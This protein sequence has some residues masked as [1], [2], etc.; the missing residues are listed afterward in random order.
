M[1][2]SKTTSDAF[3]EALD[4]I[5]E[6]KMQNAG[7]DSTI[8]G[9]IDSIVSEGQGLYNVK[10]QG[11]VLT[12]VRSAS[13]S[14]SYQVGQQVIVTLPN[15]QINSPNKYISNSL[16]MKTNAYRN[17]EGLGTVAYTQLGKTAV[18]VRAKEDMEEAEKQQYDSDLIENNIFKLC[19][20]D[21][22]QEYVIYKNKEIIEEGKSYINYISVDQN[23]IKNNLAKGNGLIVGCALQTMLDFGQTG[24]EYGI[25]IDVD[26]YEQYT[27]V[28]AT[29]TYV[30][31]SR[32]L[33]GNPFAVS[34]PTPVKIFI[35]DIKSDTY[36]KISE[37][38]LYCRNFLIQEENS[39]RNKDIFISNIMIAGGQSVGEK[40]KTADAVLLID[41]SDNI[42]MEG[43]QLSD[44]QPLIKLKAQLLIQGKKVTQGVK[45]LWFKEDGRVIGR[46]STTSP[47]E[48]NPLCFS[49][50]GGAGWNCVNKRSATNSKN[51]TKYTSPVFYFT[52]NSEDH[53][54][55]SKK[56]DEDKEIYNYETFIGS[57]VKNFEWY[58]ACIEAEEQKVKCVAVYDDNAYVEAQYRVFNSNIKNKVKII[59]SDRL[60]G[61]NQTVYYLNNGSPTLTCKVYD[62]DNKEIKPEQCTFTWYIKNNS[63]K[64]VKVEQV[65]ETEYLNAKKYFLESGGWEYKALHSDKQT[66]KRIRESTATDSSFPEDYNTYSKA[67]EKYE[68]YYGKNVSICFKNK[69]SNFLISSISGSVTLFCSVNHGGG[70]AGTASITLENRIQ[71][72]ER[73]SLEIVNATQVFKYDNKGNS[74]TSPQFDNSKNKIEIQPL[75]FNFV[76]QDGQVIP[77]ERI[78]QQG[79]AV[80]WLLPNNNTLLFTDLT[81]DEDDSKKIVTGDQDQIVN[82]A[83]LPLPASSYNVFSED[84]IFTFKIAD[85]FNDQYVDND[86]VLL[87]EY[88]DNIFTDF[89]NFTF[90]KQGDSG[91]NGTDYF[92]TIR[93]VNDSERLYVNNF[94]GIFDDNDNFK[95]ITGSETAET[96]KNTVNKLQSILYNNSVKIN[97][98][99]SFKLLDT[100]N[101]FITVSSSE[102][103]VSNKYSGSNN[104]EHGTFI[105]TF[106]QH[107][108]IVRSIFTIDSG[109]STTK[110]KSY[111]EKPICFN[112]IRNSSGNIANWRVKIK[113]KTGFQYVTYEDDGTR[114][115]YRTT[116]FEIQV[117][118][119]NSEGYYDI[120]TEYQNIHCT[121]RVRGG[122]TIKNPNTTIEIGEDESNNPI[123]EDA[124]EGISVD[125]EP[126]SYFDGQDL[127]SAVFCSITLDGAAN[128]V[129]LLCAPIYMCINRYGHQALNEWDG[130]SIDLGKNNAT[131]LAPQVGAGKKEGTTFTGIVMGVEHTNATSSAP[132]TDRTG[133]FGY[134]QGQRTIF[135]NAESGSAEFGVNN[136]GKITIDPNTKITYRRSDEATTTTYSRPA[137]L[138]YSQGLRLY[139]EDANGERIVSPSSVAQPARPGYI[140]DYIR[141][142]TIR[143]H[144]YG[145]GMIIDLTSPA[146]AFGSGNFYVEPNGQVTAAAGHIAGWKIEKTR[147][148]SQT[149]G[150]TMYLRSK[151]T[152]AGATYNMIYAHDQGTFSVSSQG[153]VFANAGRVAGWNIA[154]TGFFHQQG[155]GSST[156]RYVGIN[157]PSTPT[158]DSVAFYAGGDDNTLT[159]KPFY[160]TFGGELHSKAG[161]IANWN[162]SS[163]S[164]DNGNVG[165]GSKT[166]S[167]KNAKI[168]AGSGDKF[169]VTDDG[170][171]VA[172]AGSIAGWSLST[173]TLSSQ[174]SA[175]YQTTI[176]NDGT[177]QGGKTGGYKWEIH[178][179]GTATFNQI[180][181]TGGT[182]GGWTLHKHQENNPNDPYDYLQDSLGNV[183]LRSDG[184]LTGPSWSIN[185]QGQATFTKVIGLSGSIGS[186]NQLSGSG[187]GVGGGGTG[188]GSYV[189]PDQVKSGSAATSDTLRGYMNIV[190]E[191]IIGDRLLVKDSFNYQGINAGW[192]SVNC[193]SS[194]HGS[195]NASGV[196]THLYY[197]YYPLKVLINYSAKPTEQT[198]S[199]NWTTT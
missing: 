182:V 69:Y 91:T 23:I 115:D 101:P 68:K 77:Y 153:K 155:S 146:I 50:F 31:G 190:A 28:A 29:R 9:I 151:P 5:I 124:F 147:F 122:L 38:R 169:Y 148:S 103:W 53:V 104:I 26:T 172:T 152:S 157:K 85:I 131:I 184:T 60:K 49:R 138:L 198:G 92:S 113:P 168:W 48:M 81:P 80:K 13:P 64:T 160:V 186:G 55:L 173:D 183:T 39:Q 65:D 102:G 178:R 84:Q 165:L 79:G 177:I 171:V 123:L 144:D 4:T 116:S 114:P 24:G 174:S 76:G 163:T 176:K 141:P 58:N 137:A 193:I 121:W 108:N 74:P 149:P 36:K 42:N 7:Y 17:V 156:Y 175:G 196:V 134:H 3:Y 14:I 27:E 97:T 73:Y 8:Y 154:S 30:V 118:R 135:L 62:E 125:I 127:T 71:L 86:I 191:N 90:P 37:V 110:I 162:I 63:G 67:K 166:I 136:A 61:Q 130:N 199:I 89:T 83:G 194:L 140:D 139:D 33:S 43:N 189:D 143:T 21:K 126:K 133:L 95:A 96:K 82:N 54:P 12:N 19:S 185:A 105:D 106:S 98:G 187:I 6:N 93:T 170:M 195:K 25:E 59:S 47:E 16:E 99:A 11:S 51:P 197:G 78:K 75:S 20:Y 57:T 111:A 15:G 180:N 150:T 10:Y 100:T 107:I 41:A 18:D 159:H 34:A 179:D 40:K 70:Y 164:L 109:I 129:A 119:Y 120:V 181:A 117:Q 94:N 52:T 1:S 192:I 2:I 128:P 22:K 56:D 161:Q 142:T 112:Y 44:T 32:Q 45:Y 88:Q 145:S 87:I 167:G 188:G 46:D 72:S 35:D 158:D 66:A 132:S